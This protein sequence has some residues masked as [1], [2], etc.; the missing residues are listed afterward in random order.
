VGNDRRR[1]SPAAAHRIT[2]GNSRGQALRELQD[3]VSQAADFFGQADES[4][5]DGHQTAREV[6]SHLLFWHR[7]YVAVLQAV[8]HG[9][10]PALRA[11]TFAELNAAAACEFAGLSMS[12]MAVRL[13]AHQELLA[14]LLAE[15]PDWTADFP[16]KQLGRGAT[17]AERVS[18]ITAHVRNH[19][20]RMRRAQRQG[21]AWVRAYY[22]AELGPARLPA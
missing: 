2:A 3:V 1:S 17:V 7:E 22:S 5:A 10:E 13:C 6:L 12:L 8:A 4:L 9:Q 15:L 19:L 21:E 18:G 11:G 14:G 16:V 20:R